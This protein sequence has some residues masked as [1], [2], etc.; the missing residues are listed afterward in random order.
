[1]AAVAAAAIQSRYV[2]DDLGEKLRGRRLS[3]S[4]IYTSVFFFDDV[5]Y[6][7]END[8]ESFAI[9]IGDTKRRTKIKT[10][11]E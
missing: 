2:A 11:R 4:T 3:L 5:E 10:R 8:A 7:N 1:M 9:F 6:D